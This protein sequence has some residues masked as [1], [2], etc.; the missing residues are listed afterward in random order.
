MEK[1]KLEYTEPDKTYKVIDAFNP[2]EEEEVPEP[3]YEYYLIDVEKIVSA[4]IAIK[5]L[6]T[7]NFSGLPRREQLSRIN[8]IIGELSDFDFD[9]IDLNIGSVREVSEGEANRWGAEE[10]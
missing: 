8:H 9:E 4:D 10:V 3:E 7:D 2:P 5:V 1:L 6:K